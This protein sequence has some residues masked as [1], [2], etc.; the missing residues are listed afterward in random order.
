MSS[1]RSRSVGVRRTALLSLVSSILFFTSGAHGSGG[2]P[3]LASSSYFGG[4]G[5]QRA[6]IVVI[7]GAEEYAIGSS[8]AVAKGIVTQFAPSTWD[9]TFGGTSAWYGGAASPAGGVYAV[10]QCVPP[11]CGAVDGVGGTEAKAGIVKYSSVG[12]LEFSKSPHFFAYS[13]TEYLLAATTTIEGGLTYV[14][15]IGGGEPCSYNAWVGAKFDASGNMIAKATEPGLEPAFT[16]YCGASAAGTGSS[17]AAIVAVGNSLYI[18]GSSSNRPG[19]SDAIQRP[20]LLEYNQSLTRIWKQR[21][22]DVAGELSGITEAG[23]AL[24]AV[25][26]A[27][28]SGAGQ[29]YLVQKYDLTGN[30]LW[31]QSFGGVADDTLKSI[32]DIGGRLFAVGSTRTASAGGADA[33]IL[34]IDPATGDILSTTPWGGA[35]DDSFNSAGTNGTDLFVAGESRS[36]AVNGNSVGQNEGLFFRYTIGA[37]ADLTPPTTTATASPAANGNGWNKTN[38]SV[39]LTGADNTGGSGL[40]SVVDDVTGAFGNVTLTST[41]A[42]L[43][44]N[45]SNEGTTTM[46]YHAVDVAG[47][48]EADHVLDIRI[49]NTPPSLSLPVG[50]IAEA[51]SPAGAAVSFSASATDSGSGINVT[52]ISN[53]GG[54]T[55]PLGTTHVTF[56]A[57]DLADNVANGGFDVT[58]QDTMPPLLSLPPS[59]SRE[60]MGSVTNVDFSGMVSASDL[61]DGTR[62]V[63]CLPASGSSFPVGNTNVNCSASDN[64]GHTASGNFTVLVRD[65]TPPILSLPSNITGIE[66]TS[67]SGASV[68]FSVSATDLVNGSTTVNCSRTSP[69]LFPFGMTTV[70]CST[71]DFSGNSAYGNFTV[72][73][74]DTTPP[75]L[76]LP[77][78]ITTEATSASGA[79]VSFN[80]SAIDLGTGTRFVSCS[81]MSNSTF[82]IGSTVVTCSA[83]DG[84]GN[85]A[86]GNFTV[87][88]QDTTAP[89]LLLPSNITDD[90]VDPAGTTVNFNAASNDSVDGTRPAVCS[91]ASGSLFPVGDTTVNCSATDTHGNTSLPGHFTVHVR[92]LE[93]IAVTTDTGDSHATVETGAMQQFAAHAT[94]SDG[95][96]FHTDGTSEGCGEDTGGGGTGGGGTGGGG[97]S[98]NSSNSWLSVHFYQG[99]GTGA[100]GYMN[101]GGS[102]TSQNISADS[103]GQ[104]HDTWSPTTPI[105]QVDGT[106]SLSQVVLTLQCSDHTL[107]TPAQLVA[108]WQGTYYQGS[109]TFNGVYTDVKMFGW[110]TKSAMPAARFSVSG[111]YANGKAY[112][113]GGVDGACSGSPCNFGPLRTVE[114][115]NLATNMWTTEPSMLERREGPGVAVLNGKIY[116]AGGHIG[117]GDATKTA[118]VLDG[119]V[120]TALPEM[121]VK[122]AEFALVAAAGKLYAIGGE[123]G[124]NGSPLLASVESYT[125]GATG[126]SVEPSLSV[127]RKF[128]A[129]GALNGGNTIIVVGGIAGGGGTA[130][131]T[132]LLNIGSSTWAVGATM[133][134]PTALL[135]GA[136]IDNIFY[137]V[138]GG[139]CNGASSNGYAYRPAVPGPYGYPDGWGLMPNMRIGRSELGVASDGANLYAIGG[140]GESQAA[141]ATLEVFS[142]PPAAGDWQFTQGPFNSTC[143]SGGGD[144]GGGDNG[145]GDN[146][147]DQG[148]TWRVVDPVTHADSSIASIDA[149]GLLTAL[150]PGSALVVAEFGG[151][152]CLD[153]DMCATVTIPSHAVSLSNLS[154]LTLVY[155]TPSVAVGGTIAAVSGSGHPSGNVAITVN[156]VTTLA[157]IGLTGN[158]SAALDTH[159]LGVASSPYAI[160]YSY[161]GDSYFSSGTDAGTLTITR[162]PLTI[163]ADDASK[164]VGAS[165]PAFTATFSGFVSGDGPS[166]LSG[167]LTFTTGATTASP[168]GTYS[169]TPAGVTSGN[170]SIG[171]VSGHLDVTYNVCLLYDPTKVVKAGSTVPLKVQLCSA[172]GANVSAAATLLTAEQ[173][174]LISSTVAGTA[175]DAGNA[176]PDGNFRF[177]ET[178]GPGYAFNLKTTGLAMGIYDLTFSASADPRTHAIRFQVK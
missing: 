25:G 154:S 106:V 54:S 146:D 128:F 141:L 89:T 105:I 62:L 167:I 57:T 168:V 161:A 35:Q 67:P 36:V 27:R 175:L 143:G 155:G 103:N 3:T 86:S 19:D 9:A 33:V 64:S 173:V 119:G 150:T 29:D 100:C 111:A 58:V 139:A 174:S 163:T 107:G 60:A 96:V 77:A 170:Y 5:E 44:L 176:N 85:T 70:S 115:Y 138:G 149:N 42:P 127:A 34:E 74:V 66:V 135:A 92:A 76:T 48:V 160:V 121:S 102:F 172:T 165:N 55:F 68:S 10:G 40:A 15:G 41:G 159:A 169:V 124:S 75:V 104:V 144:S 133:P 171:F 69:S 49:D 46:T 157:A 117:G 2:T 1:P 87:T 28:V 4:P 136:T 94:F 39:T 98:T 24:Y 166:V 56:Q 31:S 142:A 126:W 22:N 16:S 95:C 153:D 21:S 47:N 37:A 99:L 73:V 88:V 38:V 32:V 151:V 52:F 63:S 14:Y 178:L 156:G 7:N 83:N 147:G 101:T 137:V 91:P 6:A 30:R 11:A 110:S 132:E 12:S 112:A 80:R 23:G 120:W 53:P 152:S 17:A 90:T 8:A 59:V 82:A 114:S 26:Y 45:V 79:V 131:A 81:R 61:V 145:G 108:N 162:A 122:R 93:S 18:A 148:P 51:T 130:G 129:A 164:I 113:I 84:R 116:V 134:S 118:E 158:F 78:N 177:D 72:T 123:N 125:P 97:T 13:G 20:V 65:T 109:V 71:V 50:A 43:V 140:Q